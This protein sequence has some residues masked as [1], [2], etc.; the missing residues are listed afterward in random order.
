[1]QATLI[2]YVIV[3]LVMIALAV[4]LIRRQVKPNF[5]YGYRMP[6]VLANPDL[7]YAVNAYF[8]RLLAGT[9]VLVV[10]VALGLYLFAGLNLKDYTTDCAAVLLI[11]LFVTLGLS[12]RYML[13]LSR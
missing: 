7:W 12:W 10:V 3:G 11:G 5:F 8:G 2:T 1:V 9:G 6:L 13:S 4:P